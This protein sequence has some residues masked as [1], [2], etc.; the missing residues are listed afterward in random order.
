MKYL[1]DVNVLVA[2]CVETHEFHS[3]VSRWIDNNIHSGD[4]EFLTCSITEL[5]YL[6]VLAQT[7]VYSFTI[8]HGKQ[9]LTQL[10]SS[11]LV[12]CEFLDDTHGAAELPRW[13][14]GPKQI[15]DGHLVQL[16]KAYGA[17]LASL[18]ENIRGAM[19]IPNE[20]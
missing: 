9:F 15:S 11:T 3:R 10:K 5:G 16:A 14:K 2:L 4:M 19:V 6:R 17:K 18:D 12:R 20:I 7:P 1:L 13:V 8:E